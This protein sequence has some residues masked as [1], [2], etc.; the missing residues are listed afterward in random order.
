MRVDVF[1]T[2]EVDL[3]EEVVDEGDVGGWLG[4]GGTVFFLVPAGGELG[5]GEVGV[6]F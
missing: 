5:G 1:A 4:R 3:A 6:W 2:T